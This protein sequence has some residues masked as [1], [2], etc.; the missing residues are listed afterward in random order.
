V[1][2]STFFTTA[3]GEWFQPT[4][5]CRGPWDP[6]SCHAGPPT[7]LMA[8]AL[9]RAVPDQRL[10]RI[11]VDLVRPIPMAGFRVETEVVRQGRSVGTTR[12]SIV[13][14][15]GRHRVTA[16]GLHLRPGEPR[17]LPTAVMS[18]PRLDEAVPGAFPIRRSRHGQPGFIG[19]VEIRYPPGQDPEPGPTTLWLR[20]LPLLPGEEPS[21][22]QRICPLADCG[23]ALSRNGEPH[24]YG[25]VNPDLTLV[26]HREPEGEW[27]GSQSI[28]HWQAD[29]LGLADALLFDRR[30]VVGRALQTLLVSP[31]AD[32]G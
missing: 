16:T 28:S 22:F 30:G 14:A 11:T 17:P 23:N 15:E 31:A 1:A 3:D 8:R 4:D 12:A 21:P 29:G 20:S 24:H 18:I 25:F 5:R 10:V 7:G 27:L 32:A 2:A 6:E 19:G 26:L 9:E 13:D